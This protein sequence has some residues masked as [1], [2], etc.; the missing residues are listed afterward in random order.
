MGLELPGKVICALKFSIC[1][2]KLS[3]LGRG[4]GIRNNPCPHRTSNLT[5]GYKEYTLTL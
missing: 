1:L 2:K 4:K 3:T 5:E